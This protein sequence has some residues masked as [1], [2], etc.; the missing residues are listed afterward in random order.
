MSSYKAIALRPA[1]LDRKIISAWANLE[2]R[3]VSPN[4][5]LSPYFVLPAIKYLEPRANVFIVFIEKEWAGSGELVAAAVFKIGKPT[6]QFPL[7]HLKTFDSLYSGL[8]GF[9]IDGDH[10]LQALTALYRFIA[11]PARPWHGFYID[12]CPPELLLTEEAKEIAARFGMQWTGISAWQRAVLPIAACRQIKLLSLKRQKEYRR[13]LRGLQQLGNVHWRAV[14]GAEITEGVMNQFLQL[15]HMGWKG[16]KGTSLL[17]NKNHTAFFNEML[18][19]FKQED[20]V[21][22][23]ELMLEKEVIASSV[24]LIS[25]KNGFGFKMGWNPSFARYSPGIVNIVQMMERAPEILKDV[26]LI[27]SSAAPGSYIEALWSRRRT[28]VE[29]AYTHTALGKLALKAVRAAKN[30]KALVYRTSNPRKKEKDG[31]HGADV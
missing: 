19:G 4:A 31:A 30:I 13:H 14:R 28:L 18:Q 25:G 2:A 12:Q 9:L 26:D 16:A 7:M 10:V 15:E 8:C 22:I 5:F 1:E 11:D 3:A 24:E 23:T 20:K 17:S 27:D 6:R 21:V 29:G